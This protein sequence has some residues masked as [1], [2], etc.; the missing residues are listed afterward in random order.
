MLLVVAA[1]PEKG[2]ISVAIIL[3][4]FYQKKKK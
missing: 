1:Q 4:Q 3:R 2:R